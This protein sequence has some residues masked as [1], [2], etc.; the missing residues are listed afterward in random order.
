MVWKQVE[1]YAGVTK[2]F[3]DEYYKNCDNVVAYRLGKIHLFD[4][5]LTLAD[6][7]LKYPPQNFVYLD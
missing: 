1:K 4:I 3:Y 2:E 5:P 7:N 6:Y